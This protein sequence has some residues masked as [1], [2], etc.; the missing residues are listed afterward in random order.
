MCMESDYMECGL[1]V[2]KLKG[3]SANMVDRNHLTLDFRSGGLD[4]LGNQ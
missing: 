2:G 1:I 4:Q 3:A